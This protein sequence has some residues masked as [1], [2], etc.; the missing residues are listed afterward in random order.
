MVNIENL[1]PNEIQ[2]IRNIPNKHLRLNFR[3]RPRP[4][5]RETQK[6]RFVNP[7]VRE[8]RN[9][10]LQVK[11]ILTSALLAHYK[12]LPVFGK[13]MQLGIAFGFGAKRQAPPNAKRTKKGKVD[14]RQ[15]KGIMDW[16]MSNLIKGVEDIMNGLVYDDDKQIRWYGPCFAEDSTSD[17]ISV[18]VWEG[19]RWSDNWDKLTVYSI[20]QWKD[21]KE[22]L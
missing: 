13:D 22:K 20:L 6:T 10:A 16:D 21:T 19:A 1:K 18:H 5:P 4:K 2:V 7:R 12:E 17:W 3:I 9:W 14:G 15:V 11:E 8:Y